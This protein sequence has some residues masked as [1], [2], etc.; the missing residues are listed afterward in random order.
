M[1][2]DWTDYK[3]AER[4]EQEGKGCVIVVN[5]WDTIPNKNQQ[6]A[7]YYEQDV[8]EKLRILDWA[9]IVYSTAIAGHSVDKSII[10]VDR[11]L[12]GLKSFIGVDPLRELLIPYCFFE[13]RIIDAASEVEKERSRRL[14]TSILNQVVL[15]AVAFKPPPR[16]RAGKRGRVYYC[17]QA[18]MWLGISSVWFIEQVNIKFAP[19]GLTNMLNNGGVIQA[20]EYVEGVAMLEVKGDGQF[21]A[22]SS[23]PPKK[24]Q[25]N[26]SDVDFEWLPNGKL[27]VNLSWIQEDHVNFPREM[28][29][30]AEQDLQ[31]L[32]LCHSAKIHEK[33]KARDNM[34][35]EVRTSLSPNETKIEQ[36]EQSLVIAASHA[37]K[38]TLIILHTGTSQ[39]QHIALLDTKPF[40]KALV[41]DGKFQSAK[42]DE[43]IYHECLVHPTLLHHP[44][45]K[46]VFI[47]GG[48]EG[49]T[50]RELLRHNTI[51]KVI[52]CDID[53]RRRVSRL[54][55]SGA[56]GAAVTAGPPVAPGVAV[57]AGLRET[58]GA[59][60]PRGEESGIG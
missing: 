39:Y 24:F 60:F 58:G 46:N 45:P 48:G 41:I 38:N 35:R 4:I 57:A 6:T 47:M 55:R 21:S 19:I 10:M 13:Q 44:N 52:M 9:P 51:D 30:Y 27:M 22:Y 37:R 8:R 14:G 23:E 40:G 7:T 53:E 32:N 20:V 28:I 2:W 26:G 49:S 3:I 11:F 18:A 16:T 43:F 36:V 17:T 29:E 15:E 50:A 56:A 42:T 33:N 5:K 1:L 34:V 59:R 12:G 31:F 25:V 54:Q